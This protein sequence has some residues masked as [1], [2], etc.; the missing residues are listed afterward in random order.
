MEVTIIRL[1]R[2][3]LLPSAR[4]EKGYLYN[5][6]Y[7]FVIERPIKDDILNKAE[8]YAGYLGAMHLHYNGSD[9]DFTIN[10]E[11]RGEPDWADKKG[12]T[13]ITFDAWMRK[14]CNKAKDK[15]NLSYT[16]I[17]MD[18]SEEVYSSSI[19]KWGLIVDEDF[20]YYLDDYNSGSESEKPLWEEDGFPF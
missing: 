6:I 18:L 17:S 10:K 19:N 11:F 7:G 15:L 12:V 20:Y 16:I 3:L 13:H 1:S 8:D 2:P 14:I 5:T 9:K 4:T